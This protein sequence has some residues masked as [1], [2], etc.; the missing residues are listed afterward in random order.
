[1]QFTCQHKHHCENVRTITQFLILKLFL[2]FALQVFRIRRSI[3]NS[4]IPRP[5]LAMPRL[6]PRDIPR[7]DLT[8]PRVAIPRAGLAT[9]QRG[10]VECSR[11]TRSRPDRVG[12]V[13]GL[14]EF[15]IN[16]PLSHLTFLTYVLYMPPPCRNG[17]AFV[18]MC[19]TLRFS[20]ISSCSFSSG[21]TRII[22][23]ALY[24]RLL[25][26]YQIL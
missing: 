24:R 23:S 21:S 5:A 3:L 7:G 2:I 4:R 20:A 14:N 6:L 10:L 16:T 18:F 12:Q 8:T 17:P 22:L 25:P 15:I 19:H 11:A 9:L 13:N 1:M 26:R